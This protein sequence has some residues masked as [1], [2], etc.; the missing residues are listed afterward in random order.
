MDRPRRGRQSPR[1]LGRGL[2]RCVVEAV[3][4][5]GLSR[6]FVEATFRRGL[7]AATTRIVRGR[8]GGGYNAYIHAFATD[9]A[10]RS[11]Q[12]ARFGTRL[13]CCLTIRL[14]EAGFRYIFLGVTKGKGGSAGFWFKAG[15]SRY[16]TDV[17]SRAMKR[18]GA[19]YKDL[20]DL[21][22]GAAWFQNVT[23]PSRCM[24]FVRGVVFRSRRVFV[25]SRRRRGC[26]VDSP[27]GR[28]AAAPRPPTRIVRR[29]GRGDA[30]AATPRLPRG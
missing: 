28:D 8:A 23:V 25:L 13:A 9:P 30:A 15:T 11:L 1:P 17:I 19:A 16:S 5:R 14:A 27:R 22:R 3:R 10:L 24:S 12:K 29:D 18:A 7:A 4:R 20:D 6:L 21:A 2:S 26:H